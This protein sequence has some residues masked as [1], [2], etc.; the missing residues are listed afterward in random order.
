MYD[1]ASNY[2]RYRLPELFGGY[3][4]EN[5]SI[6]SRYPVACSPQAWSAGTIPFMLSAVMGFTPNAPKKRLTLIKPSLPAWLETLTIDDLRVGGIPVNIEFKRIGTD[7]MVNEP[8][9]SEIDVVVHY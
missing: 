6:P 3:D 7:T 2:P 9:T 5:Y 1:A 8:G 4:R